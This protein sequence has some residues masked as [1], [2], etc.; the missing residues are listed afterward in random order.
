MHQQE[1]SAS[2]YDL[3]S[4][5]LQIRRNDYWMHSAEMGKAFVLVSCS[6]AL[7]LLVV[8]SGHICRAKSMQIHGAS[9]VSSLISLLTIYS[10]VNVK[11]CR[12]YFCQVSFSFVPVLLWVKEG[13]GVCWKLLE[14]CWKQVS[15][16][17]V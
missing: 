15:H 10:F 4:R 8:L 17:C 2:A 14:D 16:Y 7:T 9:G 5:W 13:V 6:I 3:Q 12:D 11:P 1:I